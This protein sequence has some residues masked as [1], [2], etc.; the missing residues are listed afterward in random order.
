MQL[1]FYSRLAYAVWMLKKLNE[2]TKDNGID[3]FVSYD[4]MCVLKS[5]LEVTDIHQRHNMANVLLQ[6]L[7]VDSNNMNSCF[8]RMPIKQICLKM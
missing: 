2:A 7:T 8:H 6:Y 3:L 5:H 4:I 1:T